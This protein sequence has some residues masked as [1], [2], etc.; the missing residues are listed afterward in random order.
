[1]STQ[2]RLVLMA[3]LVGAVTGIVVAG[4][5]ELAVDVS[6]DHLLDLPL[7]AIAVMPAAGL[8]VGAAARR[9]VG[10]GA[11]AAT[12]DEYLHA[13]HDDHHELGWRPLAGRLLA[14]IAS[15]GS[16]APMGLEGP[17]LYAGATFGWHVQRR[18]PKVFADTD[19][20]FLLVA[21][22]AAGVAA[23]FKAPATGVVFAL[24]VPYQDDLARRMLLPALVSSA[25][26]YLAFV[27]IHGTAPLFHIQGANAFV[28]RD[29]LGAAA[30]GVIAGAGARAFAWL[31]RAAKRVSA[32]RRPFLATLAAGLTL[33][34]L[35]SLGRIVSGQSLLVGSG[36]QV[37][38]WASVASRPIAA[39]AAIL[40]LR[41]LGTAAAVAGGGAGGLFVPLVAAG[42]LTGALVG[43]TVNQLDLSLFVIIGVAAFL[44]A[45]YR[46]PLA[47]VMFIAE[48]TGRPTFVVPGLIAAVA[49]ELMMGTASVTT[50]QLATTLRSPPDD[51]G[52]AED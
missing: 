34:V 18:L 51:G 47:S 33:A 36:Y 48:T 1:V 10:G 3:A 41:C 6:F 8:I 25:T 24:E 5:D 2:H 4:L 45:G 13:F 44:G 21:G 28:I 11:S 19:R 42:A 43:G 22:A 32:G 17:S 52:D 29:L 37:V 38:A 12:A 9:Y 50:Y 35:F 20:R 31:L 16:G 49:A 14:A 15:I 23:I 26:G 27:A 39:L 46:V 30:V 40:A 7:W